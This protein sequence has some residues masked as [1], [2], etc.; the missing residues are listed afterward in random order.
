M[1]F[2]NLSIFILG[3]APQSLIL[4]GLVGNKGLVIVKKITLVFFREKVKVWY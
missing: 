2:K 1:I 4:V 3:P